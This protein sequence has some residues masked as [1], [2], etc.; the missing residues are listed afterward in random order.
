MPYHIFCNSGEIAL[1]EYEIQVFCLCG[2]KMC[3]INHGKLFGVNLIEFNEWVSFDACP[4]K[5]CVTFN[6]FAKWTP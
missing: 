4:P 6:K 2:V 1:P 3:M 5:S